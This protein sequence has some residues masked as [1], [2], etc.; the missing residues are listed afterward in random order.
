MLERIALRAAPWVDRGSRTS[1]A[2]LLLHRTPTLVYIH[3]VV[4]GAFSIISLVVLWPIFGPDFPPGVDSPTFLHLAW[5]TKLA[6]SGDLADPF[7]DPY[8]YGGYSYLAAYPPLGYGLVGVIGAIP[9]FSF[10]VVYQIFL[11]LGLGGI[12][13]ATYWM[14]REFGLKWWGAALA[15]L[16]TGVAYPILSA[17]F[18]WG[19]FTSIVAL[20]FALTSVIL[21]E[22]GVRSDRLKIAALGGICLGAS[23]LIHHMTGAAFAMALVGWLAVHLA[24]GVNPRLPTIK[25]FALFGVVTALVVLPWGIPFLINA[26]D[27][28]FRREIPGNWVSSISTYQ[29]NI[30]RRDLIGVFTYPSYLASWLVLALATAGT[31]Y[32]LASRHRIAGVA[33]ILLVLTWF[34]MGSSA[35]P[36]IN[37]YPFSGLDIARF[38][39][40]MIPFIAVLAAW[41][42]HTVVVVLDQ[43]R[44][45]W[46]RPSVQWVWPALITLILAGIMV[47][48]IRD[49]VRSRDFMDSYQVPT[50]MT[51]ALEWL[52][53]TEGETGQNRPERLYCV[54][55]WNW[56]VFLIPYRAGVPVIDGWADEGAPNV[57]QVRPLRLTTWTF[58]RDHVVEGRK[59]HQMLS[60][61]GATHVLIAPYYSLED[62]VGFQREFRSHPD[63]FALR[64]TWGQLELYEVLPVSDV[65]VSSIQRGSSKPGIR[66]LSS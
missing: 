40:Y 43:Y 57:K 18:L 50:E 17:V 45:R 48:P 3:L 14:G 26:V 28:G 63:R 11:V 24:M 2:N 15:A 54:G 39:L 8:W 42:L 65:E 30:L 1:I 46:V 20:P 12:G 23:T 25:L 61:L 31:V 38:P 10:I 62:S 16:L 60:D 47:L 58:V 32:S 64:R 37:H 59:V 52:A 7:T 34:S 6:V 35:N 55:C 4:L 33:A 13:A 27:V 51:A 9:G 56:D 19:W 36:L 49:A 66:F 53:Q 44:Q 5:V 41:L 29:E 21:L 22:R